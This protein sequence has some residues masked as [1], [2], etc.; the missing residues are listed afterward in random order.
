MN[1]KNGLCFV[2]GKLALVE[3]LPVSFDVNSYRS[4]V[5][6]GQSEG[7]QILHGVNGNTYA[8]SISNPGTIYNVSV[9]GGCECPGFV[10]R[11]ACKH[12]AVLLADLGVQSRMNVSFPY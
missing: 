1:E 6:R 9:M 11:G 7:V 10:N 12:Y 3:F 5:Q 4:L 2:D 8:T